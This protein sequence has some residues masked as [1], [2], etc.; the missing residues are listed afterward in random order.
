MAQDSTQT[1]NDGPYVFYKDI[2]LHVQYIKDSTVR[3]DTMLADM[4]NG[5]SL[6]VQFSDRPEWDFEV[7]LQTELQSPPVEYRMP[8]KLLIVSDIEG[9]FGA[10]RALL[11]ANKIIDEKY[12]WNFGKG[13]LVIAGD[14][15]DRGSTVVE[16][17]WLLYKLEQDARE[18]GGMVHVIL[19]NHDIMNL[20][21]DYR[22]VQ[23]KYTVHAALMQRAY[24]DLFDSQTELGRWL[25]TKNIIEKVGDLLV[26]HGGVSQDVNQQGLSLAEI[27]NRSRPY[28]AT[29]HAQVPEQVQ[30]F[31]SRSGLFW[32]RGYFAEPKASMEQ[33]DSTLRIFGVQHI[34][35]GHT[36]VDSVVSTHYD[37][38]VIAV[39]VNQH[40]GQH[41]AL[42]LDHGKYYRVDEHGNRELL[43]DKKEK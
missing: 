26:L 1:T 16:Y 25:R 23:P 18:H 36:I 10:F 37:G 21:G 42:L 13:H 8:D 3:T 30:P 4:K 22:Y 33:V 41:Q 6:P 31:M 9:E 24:Q 2:H 34:V 15:F 29:P 7:P 27:N 40:D 43:E 35:V 19:G 28:Y 5:L 38:K 14:L 11:L 17:L 20:S 39:D 32:Y 12:N